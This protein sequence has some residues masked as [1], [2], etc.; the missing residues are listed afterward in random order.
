MFIHMF[1]SKIVNVPFRIRSL[2]VVKV[3]SCT[4]ISLSRPS[5]VTKRDYK[6]ATHVLGQTLL[7]LFLDMTTFAQQTQ[8][9]TGEPASPTSINTNSFS[10]LP[11][12]SSSTILA[13]TNALS[14]TTLHSPIHASNSPPATPSAQ[15]ASGQALSRLLLPRHQRHRATLGAAW[16]P[17]S[18]KGRAL[19]TRLRRP[20][21]LRSTR[22][23]HLTMGT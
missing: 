20:L 14:S 17:W 21:S 13:I 1:T 5:P 7:S 3:A 16:W 11:S 19:K 12:S 9:T 4:L 15:V 10:T 8:Q 23:S 6:D 18:R 22:T 2:R